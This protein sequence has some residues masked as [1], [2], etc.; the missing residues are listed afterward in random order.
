[1]AR[2]ALHAVAFLA[3]WLL[4]GAIRAPGAPRIVSLDGTT[5][6]T[7]AALGAQDELVGRDDSSTYPA[8][9]T[10]LPSVGYQFA[11]SAEGILSLHP[12]LAIGRDDAQ[13]AAALQQV[14][15]AGVRIELVAPAR[16]LRA[17]EQRILTIG[18]LLNRTSQATRVVEEMRRDDTVLQRRIESRAHAAPARVVV[19]LAVSSQSLLACG[20]NSGPGAMV[21]LADAVNALP[22]MHGCKPVTP[23]AIV[24]AAP[25]VVVALARGRGYRSGAPSLASVPAIAQTPAGRT[26][27]LFTFDAL[28]FAAFG[29]RTVQATLDLFDAIYRTR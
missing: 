16:T 6:E 3:G 21:A 15:T 14:R 8:S 25:D 28:F 7:V 24:A 20:P 19:F 29:P 26:Q 11:L 27:R 4:L 13:P 22:M 12:T 10:R 2:P 5:T 17:S 9:V 18:G 1:M 23:E